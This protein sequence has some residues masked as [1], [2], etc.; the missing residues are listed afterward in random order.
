MSTQKK[1]T[2][3]TPTQAVNE[4]IKIVQS[5]DV[6]AA[7]DYIDTTPRVLHAYD[8]DGHNGLYA[9]I[10]AGN[11]D[12]VAILIDHGGFNPYDIDQ[13]TGAS[14]LHYAAS[15]GHA[16]IVK[17]LVNCIDMDVNVTDKDGLPPLYYAMQF[18]IDDNSTDKKEIRQNIWNIILFLISRG[19]KYH[20]SLQV[21]GEEMH[22]LETKFIRY[23]H[24]INDNECADMIDLGREMV[25]FL[26]HDIMAYQELW[27]APRPYYLG[28]FNSVR[29][30]KT[31]QWKR[32]KI[33][34]F[35]GWNARAWDTPKTGRIS[36]EK[37]KYP[38]LLA[39]KD[40]TP[41][42]LDLTQVCTLLINRG[43]ATVAEL[44]KLVGNILITADDSNDFGKPL[45]TFLYKISIA[46]TSSEMFERMD[47]GRNGALGMKSAVAKIK[48]LSALVDTRRQMSKKQLKEQDYI[49]TIIAD[50]DDILAENKKLAADV[51]NLIMW[52]GDVR[53][54]VIAITGGGKRKLPANIRASFPSVITFHTPTPGDSKMYLGSTIATELPPYEMYL[55]SPFVPGLKPIH[56]TMP[57]V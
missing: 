42:V 24:H 20:P 54:Y 52:G 30:E 28:D 12:M 55:N 50:L 31:P 32:C 25:D 47:N 40:V 26:A 38:K 48:E 3:R 36:A 23:L 39:K 51:Q 53:V 43:D 14:A 6:M 7:L 34:A 45:D 5:G 46:T 57:V 17:H 10:F 16:E 4:F 56:I 1:K 18:L 29:L 22:Q 33:P 21:L 27:G 44:E 11:F 9:A 2:S 35:V 37:Q 49:V 19:A 8:Q 13:K 41:M 15:E